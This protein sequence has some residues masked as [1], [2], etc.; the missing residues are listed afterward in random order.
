M[1]KLYRNPTE[2]EVAALTRNGATLRAAKDYSTG[3]LYLWNAESASHNQVIAKLGHCEN[4]DS[5]GQVYDV[6]SYRRLRQ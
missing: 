5:V 4:I 2:N 3:D 1:V 6:E